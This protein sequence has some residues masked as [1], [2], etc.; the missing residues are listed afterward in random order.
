[1]DEDLTYEPLGWAV[2]KGDPDFLNW[3][4]NFLN[5]AKH[6]GLYNKIYTKWFKNDAWQRKVQ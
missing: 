1:M 4:N 5:Q 6:D 3:L 2:R